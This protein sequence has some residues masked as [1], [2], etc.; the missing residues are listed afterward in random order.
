VLRLTLCILGH[1]LAVVGPLALFWWSPLVAVSIT[2][3]GLLLA[4]SFSSAP[5]FP[6]SISR[7]F[8]GLKLLGLV[9][10]GVLLTLYA[11][12]SLQIF[13]GFLAWTNFLDAWLDLRRPSPAPET[14]ATPT[15][16]A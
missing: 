11:Q 2:I 9:A 13:G 15:E 10:F 3:T 16:A 4:G 5:A 6:A 1:V 12:R 14:P 8:L 7:T